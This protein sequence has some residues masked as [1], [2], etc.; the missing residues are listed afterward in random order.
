MITLYRFVSDHFSTRGVLFDGNRP[1]CHTLE[2]PWNNNE[3]NISC[4]PDGFY[5]VHRSTSALHGPCFRFSYVRGRSGIL[6]HAGNTIED[7][8][9]CILVGLDCNSVSVLHSRMAMDR[10][11]NSLP[12]DFD[13]YIRTV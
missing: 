10:L 9:G 5:S 4:I 1:L 12:A 11:F 2:L 3:Q 8:R 6:F 7:T 13:I